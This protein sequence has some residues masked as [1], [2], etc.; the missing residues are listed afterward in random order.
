MLINDSKKMLVWQPFKN[1]S[2]SL[3]NYLT[4]YR[5][6][7]Q[8]RFVFAQGPV[9]Y[10]D[11]DVLEPEHEPSLGHTNWF[12]K[13]ATDYTKILPIRNPYSRAVSQ[14]KHA[15]KYNNELSFDEWLLRHSKQLIKFPVS[16]V[17]RYDKLIKVENIEQELKNLSLFNDEYDFPHNNK[18][19]D[20][21]FELNE[22]HKKLIYFLHYSDFQAGGYSK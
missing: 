5:I 2:T 11:N 20:V 12:S 16:K 15:L 22:D 8:Q 1:Y 13:R 17:Y 4:S 14:W 7:R 6:F 18:S 9:P 3:A 19:D 10:L 21:D